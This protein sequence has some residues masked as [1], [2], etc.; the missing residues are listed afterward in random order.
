MAYDVGDKLRITATF[1]VA[2]TNTDPTTI[3][4]QHKDPSGNTTS[5]T[6]AADPTEVV[7][8]ATGIYYYDLTFDEAGTWYV[9]WTGTGT[10]VAV[11]EIALEAKATVI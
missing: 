7:K 2:S 5:K 1:T 10:V 3:T 4:M 6:Y 8:S 9:K 11:D